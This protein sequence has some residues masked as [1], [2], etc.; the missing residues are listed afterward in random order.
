MKTPPPTQNPRAK[1]L[2]FLT[3]DDK[4]RGHSVHLSSYRAVHFRSGGTYIG[5]P[6]VRAA[7]IDG[8]EVVTQSHAPGQG[9]KTARAADEFAR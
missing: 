9:K 5:H 2:L 6:L 1:E 8:I 7:T 4:S 3:P